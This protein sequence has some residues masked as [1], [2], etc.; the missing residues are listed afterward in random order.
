[1]NEDVTTR[2][3]RAA[4]ARAAV[5]DERSA[6]VKAQLRTRWQRGLR[7]RTLRRRI[8][9]SILGVAAVVAIAVVLTR[10]NRAAVPLGAVVAVVERVDGTPQRVAG[11]TDSSSTE[12]VSRNDAIREGQCIST[13]A[14]AR[15]GLRLSNGASLRV[16]A[17]SLVCARSA[18]AVE[19]SS[20]AIYVDTGSESSSLE[21]R[22]SMGTVRD[23]GTQ[24]EIR[25]LDRT[26]RLRVRT[27]IVELADRKQT[28]S[29][30][31]GTEI[32]LTASGAVSRPIAAHGADWEWAARLSPRIEMDGMSLTA[33]LERVARE[34]GWTVRYDDPVLREQAAGVVLHGSVADLS[35][36]EM[37]E[38][39]IATSGLQHRFDA[40]DL[41]VFRAPVALESGRR[42]EH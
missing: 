26:L 10:P 23:I 8:A 32:T 19:L 35:P 38:T 18:S 1:M 14:S 12:H 22:T 24:F 42:N 11:M 2:L 5:S 25:L 9:V 4:G 3:L 36:R 41:V 31:A 28:V 7:R 37:V 40:G 39:A 27:G 13:D 30:K 15:A 20:G 17:G 34:H 16:D 33:F 21:V 29:A 6:R